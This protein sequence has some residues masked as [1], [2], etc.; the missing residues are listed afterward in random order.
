MFKDS[1]ILLKSGLGNALIHTLIRHPRVFL[2][3]HSVKSVSASSQAW[4]ALTNHRTSRLAGTMASDPRLLSKPEVTPSFPIIWKDSPIYEHA[5]VGRVFNHR[6]PRAIRLLWLRPQPR[7]T[8]L[9][10][11]ALPTSLA[12]ASQSGLAATAGRPGSVRDDAILID[13]GKFFHFHLDNETGVLQASPSMTGRMVNRLLD[14]YGRMFPG[15]HCPDV[16]LGGFLLQGRDGWNC[17]VGTYGFLQHATPQLEL[18]TDC[19]RT[20]AFPVNGYCR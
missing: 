14:P 20:G 18:R 8:S 2:L 9:R 17:K 11:S 1:S 15:G 6:R 19:C 4:P 3:P 5:R 7:A 16:A 13:L 10:L 12:A